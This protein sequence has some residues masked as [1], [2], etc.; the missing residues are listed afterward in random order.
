M[1]ELKIFLIV[2][3]AAFLGVLPPG[4]VNM[5]VAKTCLERGKKNGMYVAIGAS[6]VILIQGFI[7]V[8]LA[9]YIFDHPFVQR[10]MLRAG[11]VI[12][13]IL[14]IY[15]FIQARNNKTEVKSSNK[16]FNN[17]FYK[18]MLIA[19]LNV[20]PI[21]Y[22]CAIAGAMNVGVGVSYNWLKITSFALAASA[23]SFTSLYLYVFSFVKIENKVEKFTEYSNYFM[24][25]LMLVLIVVTL[26][27]IYN[28]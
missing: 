19:A 6:L 12:F 13:I 21:P 2:Y 18:G 16:S 3:F 4:L 7:A 10:I 26:F 17:N 11:L 15:F 1:E 20:F 28:N 25:G 8:L 27:R 14:G 22:F 9:K 24:A 23:G 5:T